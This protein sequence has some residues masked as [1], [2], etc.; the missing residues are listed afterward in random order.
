P[1]VTAKVVADSDPGF[2]LGATKGKITAVTTTS[3]A[4]F[5]LQIFETGSV[6]HFNV[7]NTSVFSA[8]IGNIRGM[9]VGR[10]AE[11]YAKFSNG[12]Y[13]AKFV[14]SA[15]SDPSTV[16]QGVV[17]VAPTSGNPLKMAVQ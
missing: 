7:D 9:V 12:S 8:A 5:D 15:V 4:S 13:T 3:P 14:D 16:K 10:G 2:Q 11:V 6:V 17:V 1:V